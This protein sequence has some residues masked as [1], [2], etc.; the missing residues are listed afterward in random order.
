METER[1]LSEVLSEFARTLVTDFPIQAI[2]DHL[3]LRIVDVLPIT[4]A[5]VTLI[6]P[7][8]DPRYVA[9]SDDSALRFEQLQTELGEGPCLAAYDSGEAVSVPDLRL[10]ERFPRFRER[11]LDEGLAAVFTFP[12]R[13]GDHQLGALDLYRTTAG[14]LNAE[15]MRTS[16]TLADVA[17]A[18]LLNAQA[19]TDLR[20]ASESARDQSLHDALT[21]LA[22]RT[23]LEQRLSHAILRCHRSGR[24]VAILFADLDRFKAV[25]DTY[26]HHVGDELLR[27][28][29]RRLAALLRPGDTLARLSG[30]EFVILCEDL[31]DT[32]RI[33]G[34]AG[35]IGSALATKFDLPGAHLQ[36]SASVGIAF[37]GR[38]QDV[39]EQVLREADTAMYQAKRKGGA[40]HG[41]ID[42][43]EDQRSRRRLDLISDLRG[44]SERGEL[45]TEYQP[46]IWTADGGITGA[47][48]LV[49]WSHP[50]EGLIR[51][52]AFV[53]L[54]EQSGLIVEIGAWV[55]ERAC[56]DLHV[57]HRRGGCGSL[58]ISVNVS[59]HQIM[60]PGYV[61]S[62][63]AVLSDTLT[64]PGCVT[65]E[66][67]EGV[68]IRDGEHA[69]AVLTDLKGLGVQLALDDFGTGYSS[70]SYLKSF[71]VDIVKIDR[72]FID[73]LHRDTTS[74]LIVA[75]FVGL[76]HGM[77]ISVV[78]EG[79]ESVDQLGAVAS[80]DCDSYQGFYTARPMS[81]GELDAWLADVGCC[82]DLSPS[83]S[84]ALARSLS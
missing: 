2:L 25:N 26:G 50:G 69:L 67:T 46:I 34:L 37:A 11:A 32:S 20:E 55:L 33:E 83:G 45:W 17:A 68:F 62:V 47:E 75:A 40:G 48:A 23:L 74:R 80:L 78:A 3:V 71:P 35:R 9:A 42:L 72:T 22:N 52:D 12:L 10:D 29:A 82:G 43:R 7:G 15:A 8:A 53:P 13:H 44:A 54:A 27:A 6:A 38:G 57:W 73:D 60:A 58:S 64:D 1:R 41:V 81:S 51:P 36:I 5:G 79:V 24:M 28:V 66:V 61:D 70:L 30:D 56:R 18:Y 63:A 14:P 76:A 39:P 59:A 16:Q 21:G 31:D 19:R 4:A 49:R 77:G 84:S 65:L